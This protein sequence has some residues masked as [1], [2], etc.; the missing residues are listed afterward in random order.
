[1]SLMWKAANQ[2]K[3]KLQKNRGMDC[4]NTNVM[5]Q[6]MLSAITDLDEHVHNRN[7]GL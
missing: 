2:F 6:L 4:C 5:Q 3:K 7:Q 1:M